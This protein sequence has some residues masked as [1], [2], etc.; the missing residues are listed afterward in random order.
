MAWSQ[1]EKILEVQR[2]PRN[3][4]KFIHT[5]FGILNLQFFLTIDLVESLME[6]IHHTEGHREKIIE[7]AKREELKHIMDLGG[8]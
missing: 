2:L 6:F 8:S 7:K 5:D 4:M 3:L 1:K